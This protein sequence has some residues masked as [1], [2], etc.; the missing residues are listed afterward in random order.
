MD[1][2]HQGGELPAI[3]SSHLYDLGRVFFLIWIPHELFPRI[4]CY[5]NV[6][7]L[8]AWL[9]LSR[10]EVLMSGFLRIFY[11][12]LKCLAPFWM[13]EQILPVESTELS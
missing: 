8:S 10:A 1:K 11:T 4:F 3:C 9:A 12:F 5:T 6:T 7:L 13:L 2:C